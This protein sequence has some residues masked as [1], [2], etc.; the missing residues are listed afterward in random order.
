MMVSVV[1]DGTLLPFQAIYVGLSAASRP[2]KMAAYYDEVMNA[3]M[4]LEYL[5]TGMYWSNMAM[6]QSFVDNI[7]SAYFVCQRNILN[8]PPTQKALWQI[9]VWSVHRSKEFHEW[10]SQKHDDI[11][12]DFIPGGCTG[13]A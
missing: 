4:L 10:M 7:L 12:M 13:L 1:N 3:E 5:G 9:D 8:L 11:I 2:S 6:M